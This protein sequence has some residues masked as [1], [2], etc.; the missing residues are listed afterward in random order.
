M[1]KGEG[2]IIEPSGL[3]GTIRRINNMQKALDVMY[4]IQVSKK[5]IQES[6]IQRYLKHELAVLKN[7]IEY[8]AD[9]NNLYTKSTKMLEKEKRN[10]EVLE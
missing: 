1:R 6:E 8:Y 2:D 3:R 10:N 9:E 5:S 4:Y 7:S